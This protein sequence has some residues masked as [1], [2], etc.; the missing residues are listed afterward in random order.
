MPPSPSEQEHYEID[1]LSVV[2]H[3]LKA[4]IAASYGFMELVEQLGD[5]N[6]QQV[7]YLQRAMGVM[8][9]MERMIA[10][11]LDFAYIDAG[12]ELDYQDVDLLT[13][14]DEV[15]EYLRD[16]ATQRGIDIN[17]DAIVGHTMVPADSDLLSHVFH[18]L[19]SNAIKYNRDD[20]EIHIKVRGQ[21]PVMRVD[22]RDTGIGI[23][24]EAQEKVFE[25]FYRAHRD[26]TTRGTGL[27]LAIS[28]MVIKLHDGD[29]WVNSVPDE[30]STFSFTLPMQPGKQ[31]Q[32]SSDRP[33]FGRL[34]SER[35]SEA[36]DAVDDS[37]QESYDSPDTESRNDEP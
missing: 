30:G 2:A 6:E 24:L 8:Q 31:R 26:K 36:S 10:T 11:M 16:E 21:G 27:G 20:G 25:R 28:R 3:D 5:L 37:R 33:R 23:P 9:R 22:V 13:L 7:R 12:I 34:P 19:I 1:L 14:V 17:I 18:N 4:P 15:L 32:D 29:I 35:A